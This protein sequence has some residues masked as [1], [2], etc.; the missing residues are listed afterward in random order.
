MKNLNQYHLRIPYFAYELGQK[1]EDIVNLK[2]LLELAIRA[3]SF[4]TDLAAGFKLA[5]DYNI[6]KDCVWWLGLERPKEL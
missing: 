2:Q 4:S 5:C 3:S 6:P 1:N